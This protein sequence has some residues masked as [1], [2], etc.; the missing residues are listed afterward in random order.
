ME[1][2]DEGGSETQTPLHPGLT[3]KPTPMWPRPRI[4]QLKYPTEP[5]PPPQAPLVSSAALVA[6]ARP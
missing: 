2:T 4:L 3:H 5:T 6:P 1:V